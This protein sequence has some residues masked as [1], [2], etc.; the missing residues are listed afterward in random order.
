MRAD[1]R[2]YRFCGQTIVSTIVLP[3]LDRSACS[4][5][6]CTIDREP[7]SDP[8]L[9]SPQFFHHWRIGRQAP[10]LSFARHDDGYLLRF[11]DLADFLVSGDGAHICACPSQTLPDDTLRHLLLD[12]VLPLA[13][14]RRGR[15]LLHASAVHVPGIGALA[16]AGPTGRGKST[17]AAALASRGGRILSDDCLVVEPRPGGL[18]VLPSYPGLRLWPDARSRAL[19][20]GTRDGRVAHYTRKRRVNGG[21]LRF[22][23]DPSPLRALF[24]LSE[25]GTAGFAVTIRRCRASARLMGLV[26][27]AYILDIEDR[28]HLARAF[29]GL[30]SL[31]TSVPVLRLRV[32]HG[33]SRLAEVADAIC[34]YAEA[35]PPKQELPP[36]GGSH[37][38]LDVASRT[39]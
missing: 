18:H 35:L 1:A 34:A 28:E 38:D 10:W 13:L 15:V 19:R 36:E 12:Q 11:R 7:P 21:A 4:E 30:A 16:F 2:A 9:A 5:P 37:M 29:D 39:V 26:K 31:V 25:R 8:A 3:L 14:S 22:H 33:H 6:A 23:R 27:Y 20:R 32:R 24:L 17:L